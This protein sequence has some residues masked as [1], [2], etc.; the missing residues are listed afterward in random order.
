MLIDS[1]YVDPKN[2][3]FFKEKYYSISLMAEE[4]RTELQEFMDDKC[5]KLFRDHPFYHSTEAAIVIKDLFDRDEFK[6]IFNF[7]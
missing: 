7:N 4:K 3:K 5:E 2:T 1:G 6:K